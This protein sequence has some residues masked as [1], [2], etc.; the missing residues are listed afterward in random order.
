MALIFLPASVIF[1]LEAGACNS[2]RYVMRAPER[3]TSLNMH[4]TCT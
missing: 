4:A 2:V 3:G 1:K